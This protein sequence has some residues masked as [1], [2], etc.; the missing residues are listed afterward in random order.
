L[1][2]EGRRMAH[3]PS[4]VV[5]HI[6]TFLPQRAFLLFGGKYRLTR[7][8][9]LR[10]L[11][12]VELG[13]V[14][15]QLSLPPL[16]PSMRALVMHDNGTSSLAQLQPHAGLQLLS[17]GALPLYLHH[18]PT[19]TNQ[20]VPLLTGFPQ[21]RSLHLSAMQLDDADGQQLTDALQDGACRHL[22]TLHLDR[23]FLRRSLP[24]LV[25]TVC[26]RGQ[27]RSLELG[28]NPLG[29]ACVEALLHVLAAAPTQPHLRYLGLGCL[30]WAE[31][32]Q[33]TALFCAAL[34][35]LAPALV[36]LV[37][38]CNNLTLASVRRIALLCNGQLPALQ[39]LDLGDNLATRRQTAELTQQL[40][41]R[42]SSLCLYC[43][44]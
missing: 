3:L 34:P 42:L 22:H 30:G 7:W 36:D 12:Y 8:P 10:H 16:P 40:S 11:Q 29:Q 25:A 44:F 33:L 39:H 38:E 15:L 5:R 24:P 20:G 21:L 31:D 32:P 18:C 37:V 19:V 28:Y 17:L 4:E 1:V 2:K 9:T 13:S 43:G 35:R 26:T 14:E 41:T 23:N 27:L 6:C